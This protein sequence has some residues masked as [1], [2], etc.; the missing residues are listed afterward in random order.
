[1]LATANGFTVLH[2]YVRNLC[3]SHLYPHRSDL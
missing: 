3:G 1:L 2:V